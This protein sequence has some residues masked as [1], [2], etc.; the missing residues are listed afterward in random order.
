MKCVA[1][2]HVIAIELFILYFMLNGN[3]KIKKKKQKNVSNSEFSWHG[4]VNWLI[5]VWQSYYHD[6][7]YLILDDD[8]VDSVIWSL[9]WASSLQQMREWEYF[10]QMSS[11]NEWM[12]M[13]DTNFIKGLDFPVL[14]RINT[15]LYSRMR[16]KS[17]TKFRLF[18]RMRP[19]II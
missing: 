14:I 2:T 13:N 3:N 6:N 10:F 8:D 5:E 1:A 16:I 7:I 17:E 4:L 19:I 11:S 12:M 18:S 9:A 15:D